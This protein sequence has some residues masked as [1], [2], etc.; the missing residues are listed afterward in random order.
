MVNVS[1]YDPIKGS[2]KNLE[3]VNAAIKFDNVDTGKSHV[4]II[5]QA[6]HVPTM[7]HNLLYPVRM[8]MHGAMVNDT[9]K[10][11][12]RDPTNDDHCVIL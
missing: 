5:N 8:R 11:L 4:L 10:F 3:V 1:G 12:L 6:V 7:E 2:A 9:P